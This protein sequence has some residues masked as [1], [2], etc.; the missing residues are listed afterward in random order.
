MQFNGLYQL[1]PRHSSGSSV[2]ACGRLCFENS[3]ASTPAQQLQEEAR[4][5]SFVCVKKRLCRTLFQAALEPVRLCDLD[6]FRPRKLSF[7]GYSPGRIKV[8]QRQRSLR[9]FLF[10][11]QQSLERLPAVGSQSDP[12]LRRL[13]VLLLGAH[14]DVCV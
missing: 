8:V 5:V 12:A 3:G 11:C 1:E 14:A 6:H 4:P 13:V 7:P 9:T 2:H 10:L